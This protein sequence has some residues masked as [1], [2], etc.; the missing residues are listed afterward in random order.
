MSYFYSQQAFQNVMNQAD[1]L[2]SLAQIPI[3]EYQQEKEAQK[4]EG[5]E[6]LSTLPFGI[7]ALSKL[8]ERAKSIY[9]AGTRLK[10]AVGKGVKL[11]QEMPEKITTLSTKLED[12]G[13]EAVGKAKTLVETKA[14]ELK[15]IAQSTIDKFKSFGQEKLNTISSR[16]KDS[17]DESV[18][19]IKERLPTGE[20]TPELQSKYNEITELTKSPTPENIA[21][22]QQSFK[23]FKASTEETLKNITESKVEEVSSLGKK[24]ISKLPIEERVN[25]YKGFIQESKA[26]LDSNIDRLTKVRDNKIDDLTTRKQNIQNKLD[27]AT[28]RQELSKA[29]PMEPKLVSPETTTY[30]STGSIR[31]ISKPVE[32]YD[33]N[34]SRYKRQLD[35]LNSEIESTTKSHLSQIEQLTN[36]HLQEIDK[37]LQRLGKIAPDEVNNIT[38]RLGSVVDVGQIQSKAMQTI[39][40]GKQQV[41]KTAQQFKQGTEEFTKAGGE[42]VQ[43]AKADLQKGI[44]EGA[45]IGKSAVSDAEQAGKAGIQA[46]KQIGEDVAENAGKALA[47]SGVADVVPVVGEIADAGILFASLFTGLKDIFDKP[48]APVMPSL[49]IIHQA[50]VY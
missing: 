48:K 5:I 38:N 32:D 30:R 44:Q 17:I 29:E 47:E 37:P 19:N 8:S 14:E 13:T 6:S 24:A 42:V 46:G 11:A 33:T 28:R 35:N 40:E 22:L 12:I 20:L 27:E 4:E 49:N 36:S 31:G 10:T 50:G 45:D 16:V 15:G 3:E 21:K 1:Q 43:Q 34:I 7:E 2:A 25:R 9:E 39:E 41:S 18:K 23:D 26:K